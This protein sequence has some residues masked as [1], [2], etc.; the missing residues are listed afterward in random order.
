MYT[1]RKSIEEIQKTLNSYAT[2][3]LWKEND[4]SFEFELDVPGFSKNEIN[5]S[6]KGSLINV[7]T[8]PKEKN[9]R[10]SFAVEYKLPSSALVSQTSAT[11]ENGVLVISVPKKES[12]KA[13]IIPIK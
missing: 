6:A 4:S 3:D 5:I 7:T 11:L 10:K 9:S 8:V 2:L 12:E 13:S 1:T